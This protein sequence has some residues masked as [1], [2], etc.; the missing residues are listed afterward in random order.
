MVELKADMSLLLLPPSSNGTAAEVSPGPFSLHSGELL[1]KG[2]WGEGETVSCL[3]KVNTRWC[4]SSVS[5]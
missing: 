3:V 2:F 1:A 4:P 5:F